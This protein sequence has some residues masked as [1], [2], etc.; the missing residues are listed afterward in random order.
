VVDDKVLTCAVAT[1]TFSV[2]ISCVALDK[3][4]EKDAGTEL[5]LNSMLMKC[6]DVG[7]VKSLLCRIS[8]LPF[9]EEAMDDIS[10]SID[11][12]IAD[13]YTDDGKWLD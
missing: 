2:A 3:P 4:P 6:A 11:A 5:C 13:G 8:K 12:N 7:S 9:S 10:Q 1:E